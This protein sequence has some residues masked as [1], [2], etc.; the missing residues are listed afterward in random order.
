MESEPFNPWLIGTIH[1]IHNLWNLW[2]QFGKLKKFSTK[3]R[4]PCNRQLKAWRPNYN[5]WLLMWTPWSIP[6][7][8]RQRILHL[9]QGLTCEILY[10]KNMVEFKH[11]LFVSTFRSS[12]VNNPMVGF[13]MLINFLLI[14]KPTLIIESP[15]LLF[16]WRVKP[17]LG[18]RI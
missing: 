10:L 12:V 18:F 13:I 3:I 7:G 2:L 1:V 5:L 11:E 15:L 6:R 9:G 4:K 8:S 14:I 17:S 16:T